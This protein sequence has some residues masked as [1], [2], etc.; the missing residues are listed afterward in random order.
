MTES[1]LL[2]HEDA[3]T[4]Q[5]RRLI[6][7]GDLA[8]GAKLTVAA[9]AARLAAGATPVRAALKLLEGEG[10][11]EA[12][13]YRG[14]RVR[15]LATEDIRNLYRLRGAVLSVLIPDVVRHVSNA[16]LDALDALEARF[17][18]AASAG[19]GP[20]AMAVNQEFHRALFATARNPD[21]AA[22]M[23]RSWALVEALRLRLGFSPGRLARSVE[24]HRALLAALRARD[25]AAATRLAV[26]SSDA[27][28]A[29]LLERAAAAAPPPGAARGGRAV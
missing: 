13:P 1:S 14:A 17:E 6:V 5:L 9:L 16:G 4:A 2:T 20:A 11:V 27:A 25:A 28:M 22:V 10:L 8:P 7:D 18:A 23:Q 26:A 19:D 24:S 12:L 29:D 3:V 21:A 15:A